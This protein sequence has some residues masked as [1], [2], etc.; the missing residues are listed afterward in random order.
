MALPKPTPTLYTVTIPST[1][2]KVKFRPFNVK[3][4]RTLLLAQQSEEL[5]VMLNAIEE[6]LSSC[7]DDKINIREL[8]TFDVEYIMTQVRAKSVGE[9]VQLNMPCDADPTHPTIPVG[10]DLTK[11][12]VN[13]P[14]GHS[15]TIHLYDDVGV[16]MKYPTIEMLPTLDGLDGISVAAKC[17]DYIY[18]DQEIFRAAEQTELEVI[19]FMESLNAEQFDKLENTFFKSMPT[20]S[21][22]LTYKCPTCGHEHRKVIRGFSSFLV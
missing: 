16:V 8:P 20:F 22:T 5:P 6:V 11:L 1:K 12:Q 10:I 7:I 9:N 15:N 13:I 4:Q 2:K 19:E 21:H 14:E 17:V 18:T 3:E